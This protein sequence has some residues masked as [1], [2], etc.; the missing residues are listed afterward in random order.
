MQQYGHMRCGCKQAGLV[1]LYISAITRGAAKQCLISCWLL[2]LTSVQRVAACVCITQA[3][4]KQEHV[5]ACQIVNVLSPLQQHQ[6]WQDGN[7]FQ[8]DRERP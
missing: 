5:V 7:C 1:L 2:L 8:V 3:S 6:L 4:P